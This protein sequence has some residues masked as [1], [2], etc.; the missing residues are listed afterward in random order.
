M[1][2]V[3]LA[4]LGFAA[5]LLAGLSLG[6][7]PWALVPALAAGAAALWRPRPRWVIPLVAAG[8]G[9]MW[10]GAA[11]AG[12]ERDCRVRWPDGAR[13]A[14]VVEPTDLFSGGT[15]RFDVR[16]PAGC[17]GALLA[18][19]P[20]PVGGGDSVLVVVGVWRREPAPRRFL[21]TRPW[22]AGRLVVERARVLKGSLGARSRLRTGAE[23]RIRALF[24][25]GRAPLAAAL[26][27]GAAGELSSEV[28]QR[29]AR[30]GLAH[31]LAI[32]GLH[33]GILAGAAIV[34]LRALRLG[35]AAARIVAT[36][37]VAGYVWLLGFPAPAVR[38]A[39]LL[40]LWCWARV[41]QRP[42]AGYAMLAT[43]AMAVLAI[44]PLAI[45]D[46]GPWLSFA[47]AWGC[48][49]AARRW[50]RVTS[51]RGA[52]KD[53]R[54]L[55]ALRLPVISTGAT[56]AT[57]P[58]SILAFGT[59][60]PAAIV[61]NVAAIPVAGF[62]VPALALSLVLAS[63]PLS[64]APTLASLPASAAGLGLDLLDWVSHLAG[65]L[66]L[67][68]ITFERRLLAAAAVALVAWAVFAP[69]RPVSG[70]SR[71]ATGDRR[72]LLDLGR[73][74]SLGGAVAA[75]AW[76]WW[77]LLP[78][79]AAGYSPGRLALHFLSVGQ[80]DG[81][82]IAT[83]A[84]RWIVI[85]GGPRGPG[86]DAGARIVV[87]FLRRHGARRL[88]VLVA[89]HGDADHLGGLPAV[90][91]AEPVDLVIEPG[92]PRIGLLY[93]LW[94]EAVVGDGA[95]YHRARAGERFTLDGVTFR[96][97]HPDSAWLE[98]RLPANESSVVLVIE[99]GSFRA[100]FPGDAGIP[101]EVAR[102]TDVGAVTVLKVGH[103]GS[104]T[105]SGPTWLEALR[106][107]L[108]VIS[109]GPNH[110]G[111][112]DP[113]TVA[114]LTASGCSLYRTDRSEGEV[115]VETDGASVT[116]RVAPGRDSTFIISGRP[117]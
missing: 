46:P 69:R 87:P 52:A 25:P 80:G 49:T 84:G 112:P 82:V 78:A 4:A 62:A 95:R 13:V 107:R 74:L 2:A 59:M 16:E 73:R 38:A 68:S 77:P 12:L 42:P 71:L 26:T 10:G 92:E 21:P 7:A 105:A 35:P 45:L 57:A 37:L 58:V 31:L 114:A 90:L 99:Y 86:F 102:A 81:A 48:M 65:E 29:F 117:R 28:R 94:L 3:V 23:R 43:T 109:V 33:V 93:S 20:R 108:C 24:G 60:A 17:R 18:V 100:V 39:A 103:H 41:R 47:G 106:P 15:D 75:A 98:R 11:R 40:A 51:G 97:V 22:R 19:V 101:M 44:D 67:A 115:L 32:S 110:Y 72:P 50:G 76:V 55:R 79:G 56:L 104:R 8:A 9:A 88:A 83:P 6:W 30:A 89:S 14:L 113:G 5:G 53:R 116:V 34:L 66:P 91:A 54:L 111:H 63:L 64:F 36:S 61:A 96:V 70:D 27:V 1:P 85:D